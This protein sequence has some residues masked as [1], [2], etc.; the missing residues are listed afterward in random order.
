MI[1]EVAD[2]LQPLQRAEELQPDLILLDLSLPKLNGMA[3][4][5]RIHKLCPNSKI[6]F[7]TQNSDLEI[8][9]AALKLGVR[10]Y[11]LKSDAK[12]LPVAIDRVLQG[13]IFVSGHLK[14]VVSFTSSSLFCRSRVARISFRSQGRLIFAF[15]VLE[16]LP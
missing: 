4:A 6:L 7:V 2:G 14:K 15:P 11:I 10:G 12:E 8:A 16:V 5:R 3:V 1:S 13:E 9:R